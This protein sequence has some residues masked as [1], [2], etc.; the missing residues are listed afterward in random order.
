[1]MLLLVTI[2]SL[3]LAVIMGVVAWRVAYEERR[4]SDARVAALAADI[5]G[6]L[7]LHSRSAAAVS[8]GGSLFATAGATQGASR[9]AAMM[10][11][12]VLVFASA[13]ALLVL[14]ASPS[15]SSSV[16]AASAP[17]SAVT[18]TEN[19]ASA[20]PLPLELMSLGHER[21]GDRLTVHGVVRNPAAGTAIEGV[22]AVV[23]LF[24]RDGGFVGSGR[25]AIELPAL[26]PGGESTFVVTVP[27]AANV[28][29][30]RVSFR[31]DDRIVPHVDRRERGQE[32]S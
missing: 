8:S 15:S 7:E 31:T 2:V 11:V 21:N 13:A 16:A 10:A 32:K 19:A 28:G 5:H 1:M 24:N 6:D 30:Y 12:G 3:L 14:F 29:R 26:R 22:T 17:A 20:A 23:F 18:S 4:R 27:D 9:F 25:A